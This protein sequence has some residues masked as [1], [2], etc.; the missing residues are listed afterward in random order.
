M[1]DLLCL[2][3]NVL[4]VQCTAL[5]QTK[6]PFDKPEASTVAL[7]WPTVIKVWNGKVPLDANDGTM[8]HNQSHRPFLLRAIKLVCP[9]Q[10]HRQEPH[11]FAG[12]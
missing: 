6:T 3:L 4:I 5:R 8:K 12:E 1:A 2:I 10:S 9:S 11:F 7:Y